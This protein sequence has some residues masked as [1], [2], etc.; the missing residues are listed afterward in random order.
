MKSR[1]SHEKSIDK[2]IGKDINWMNSG[3]QFGTSSDDR[4]TGVPT[5]PSGTV[6]V[7]GGT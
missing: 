4:A 1:V 5:D 7:V 6:N 2:K 3:K